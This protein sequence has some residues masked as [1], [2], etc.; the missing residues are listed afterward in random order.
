MIIQLLVKYWDKNGI[1]C[2]KLLVYNETETVAFFRIAARNSSPSLT[3]KTLHFQQWI[4]SQFRST[5]SQKKGRGDINAATDWIVK[6]AVDQTS[7][8]NID[9]E[10]EDGSNLAVS[11]SELF[12]C[13]YLSTTWITTRVTISSLF[14]LCVLMSPY[15]KQK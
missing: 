13:R 11:M 10:E 3:Y 8:S 1:K 12:E 7:F 15:F 6:N 9:H 5:R 4:E 2:I 14:Q